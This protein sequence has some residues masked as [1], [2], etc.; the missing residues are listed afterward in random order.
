MSHCIPIQFRL[1]FPIQSYHWTIIFFS[2]QKQIIFPMLSA[3]IVEHAALGFAF[4]VLSLF[5]LAFAVIAVVLLTISHSCWYRCDA[6]GDPLMEDY[7]TL[8]SEANVETGEPIETVVGYTPKHADI[9]FIDGAIP[10]PGLKFA[11][12]RQ[13]VNTQYQ[14]YAP[15]R[16]PT[17]LRNI[18]LNMC[19]PQAPEDRA[20]MNEM[21]I[22]MQSVFDGKVG[23]SNNRSVYYRTN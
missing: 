23:V 13:K 21:R 7:N 18:M 15:D 22:A 14:M 19:W 10:Y 3:A 9:I 5:V 4:A 8:F 20:N 16:M 12:V 1:E 11:E 6:E 2:E 17:F